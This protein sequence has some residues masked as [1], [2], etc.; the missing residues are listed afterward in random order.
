MKNNFC[1]SVISPDNIY[2]CLQ[3]VAQLGVHDEG[4]PL[5]GALDGG[6]G[7]LHLVALQ[8][9]VPHPLDDPAVLVAGVGRLPEL[10]L[11][12]ERASSISY[13]QCSCECDVSIQS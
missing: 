12:G 10:D 7:A 4:R 1:R 3:R 2:L 6:E 5:V 8:V 9:R 11:R 13:V